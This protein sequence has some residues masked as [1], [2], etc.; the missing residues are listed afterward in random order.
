MRVLAFPLVSWGLFALVMWGSHFSPLFDA[1]LEDPFI[2]LV[3]HGLS[4]APRC[5]SGG[6]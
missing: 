4:W 6:R 1:A 5:C 2:H 3:E